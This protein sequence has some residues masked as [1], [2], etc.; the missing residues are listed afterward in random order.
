M[1]INEQIKM[2][3]ATTCC[4]MALFSST[5][6]TWKNTRRSGDEWATM[7]FAPKDPMSIS[8]AEKI[9]SCVDSGGL[10]DYWEGIFKDCK[11]K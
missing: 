8:D 11:K 3:I 9:K 4:I 2:M 6:Y 10:P 5:M 1:N 7:R